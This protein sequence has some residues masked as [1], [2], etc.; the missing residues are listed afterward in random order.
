MTFHVAL[1]ACF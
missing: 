1:V